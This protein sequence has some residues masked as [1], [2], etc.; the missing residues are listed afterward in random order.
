MQIGW[1]SKNC[2]RKK[3]RNYKRFHE[4]KLCIIISKMKII[5]EESKLCRLADEN[6]CYTKRKCENCNS[7][8]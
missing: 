4:N 5:V 6:F 3:K 8:Q 2:K 1:K 7:S